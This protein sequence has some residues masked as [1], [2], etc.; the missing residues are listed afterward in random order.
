MRIFVWLA[1]IAAILLAGSVAVRA[2]Q[3]INAGLVAYF[4]FEG[5]CQ[6]ASSIHHPTTTFGAIDYQE[7]AIG[8][9]LVLNGDGCVKV[10]DAP[11]LQLKKYTLAAWVYHVRT[12]TN[13]RVLEKGAG[14]AYWLWM[15]GGK[16]I[17]GFY[18]ND[19]TDVHSD[20][21]VPE[22]KWTYVCTTYDGK[23]QAIYINGILETSSK[24]EEEVST[25]NRPLYIGCRNAATDFWSGG[26][27]EVR[28][29]NRALNQEEI[30][31]LFALKK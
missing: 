15:Y 11:A 14:Q 28:I 3:N 12:N 19:Y 1:R 24:V 22:A 17:G 29:Y 21:T 13:A 20:S 16:M 25:T 2:Q 9:C 4:P 31:A 18:G 30:T 7:G 10:P 8:Q 23:T 26:L 27:D 5:N 6:D